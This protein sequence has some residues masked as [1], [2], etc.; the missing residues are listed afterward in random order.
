MGMRFRKSVKIAPGIKANI[1][2]KSVGISV[3]NK[4]GGVNINSKTGVR[5]R[6]S[7]PGTGIS[8]SESYSKAKGERG[9][10]IQK[11][12][13]EPCSTI[14]DAQTVRS[15]NDSAF[16]DYLLDYSAYV[17]SLSADDPRMREAGPQINLIMAEQERRLNAMNWDAEEIQAFNDNKLQD[18]ANKYI[19][20][21]EGYI[22]IADSILKTGEN[23]PLL[24]SSKSPDEISAKFKEIREH[25]SFLTEELNRR[26]SY[27]QNGNPAA[28]KP[29]KYFLS[30]WLLFIGVPIAI[31]GL[32]F[33][34]FN[35]FVPGIITFGVGLILLLICYFNQ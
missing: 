26:R 28:N 1:G 14:L 21:G 27:K 20:Y 10:T 6:T 17:K 2:K 32:V 7:I 15:L 3:E 4:Y 12:A 31:A 16:N 23:G 34:F 25:N 33:I 24:F 5:G 18:Y 30:F 19:K 22:A 9:T 8:F 35:Y 29:L 11:E 13:V